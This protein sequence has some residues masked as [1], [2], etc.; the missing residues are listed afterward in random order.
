MHAC[1]IKSWALPWFRW[2][3]IKLA[4]LVFAATVRGG[5]QTKGKEESPPH[6]ISGTIGRC[7]AAQMSG[8]VGV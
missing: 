6:I 8:N 4:R 5:F 3:L 1:A 2:E 7:D